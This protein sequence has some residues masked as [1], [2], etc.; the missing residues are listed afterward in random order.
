MLDTLNM[1]VPRLDQQPVL[2]QFQVTSKAYILT[3]VHRAANTE[4]VEKLSAVLDC[5]AV[6]PLPVLFPVHPRTAALLENY[7]LKLPPNV[8]AVPPISYT[9]MLVLE[10]NACF[11]L[12]DSG[13]VQKEAYILAVPCIT[14][15]DE[16]EW[17]ETLTDGW[18]TLVGLDP[19]K[20][21]QALNQPKERAVPV[22][23]YG[24]GTAARQITRILAQE[25]R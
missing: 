7:D 1:F 5:L 8:R 16:T 25:L 15:R 14:L 17:D 11:I 10:K 2:D 20:V 19:Q 18:N 9:Q 3:T 6:S 4:S 21:L 13:G 12:T 22:P 24:D 23:V